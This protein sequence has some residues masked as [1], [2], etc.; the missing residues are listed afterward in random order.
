VRKQGRLPAAKLSIAYQLE[1]GEAV[2]EI[3]SDAVASGQR[4][5]VVD[6]LLATGG[7]AAAAVSLVEQLGGRVAGVAFLVELTA[8]GGADA[9]GRHPH[10]SLIRY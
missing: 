2:L 5:L 8:L 6:D 9:L 4:V 10:T 7:T 1:Y 3:H